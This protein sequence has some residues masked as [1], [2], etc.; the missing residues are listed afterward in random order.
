MRSRK[1][2]EALFNQHSN[3]LDSQ[4]M[5][6]T[7]TDPLPNLLNFDFPHSHTHLEFYEQLLNAIRDWSGVCGKE[8]EIQRFCQGKSELM[9]SSV[10]L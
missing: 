10:S 2:T 6:D 1:Q 7:G 5:L 8:I 4:A 9:S 3:D